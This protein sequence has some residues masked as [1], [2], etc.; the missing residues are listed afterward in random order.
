MSL[1][2]RGK[3]EGEGYQRIGGDDDRNDAVLG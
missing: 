2:G 3:D 1:L